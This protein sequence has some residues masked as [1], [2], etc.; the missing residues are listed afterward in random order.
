MICGGRENRKWIYFSAGLPFENIFSRRTGLLT[1][2]FLEKAFWNLLKFIFSWG[3][4]LKIYFFPRK[5]FWN[6]FFP[7][8]GP[9]N[10]F[11]LIASGPTPRSLMIFPQKNYL[12]IA[13]LTV[14][15][16]LMFLTSDRVPSGSPGR[17]IETLAST[18][19]EPSEKKQQK[20]LL[21]V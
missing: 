13:F 17:R 1:F 5:A 7:W 21:F 11:L 19:I 12:P 18:L 16:L 15:M 4:H 3:R 2:F 10:F 9:P 14:L 8:E 6:I 20:F